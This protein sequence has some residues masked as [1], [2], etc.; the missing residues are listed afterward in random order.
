MKGI[1]AIIHLANIANDPAVE[2]NHYLSWKFNV[3]ASQQLCDKA[4]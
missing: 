2:L 4:I 1:D 3:L